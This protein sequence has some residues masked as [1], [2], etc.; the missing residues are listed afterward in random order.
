MTREA[1]DAGGPTRMCVICRRRLPKADLDRF[2]SVPGAEAPVEDPAQRIQARGFY[3]CR[4]EQCVERS[5]KHG[6]FRRK[7]KGECA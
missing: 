4:D 3:R 6:M 7:P 5:R 1:M 2:V